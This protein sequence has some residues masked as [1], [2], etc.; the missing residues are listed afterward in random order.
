PPR[1]GPG[2]PEEVRRPQEP[3]SAGEVSGP[4]G[5]LGAAVRV[6]GRAARFGLDAA[7]GV[8]KR[9]PRP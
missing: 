9:L 5:A 2:A 4:G 8:L 6:A 1:G 3:S 7:G